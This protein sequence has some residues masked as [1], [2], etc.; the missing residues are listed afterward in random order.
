MK[1]IHKKIVAFS[2]CGVMLTSVAMPQ[3]KQIIKVVG[4]G[5]AVKQF[6]KDINRAINKLANRSD[7]AERMTKVVPILTV[8]IGK[9]NAIGA[10]QVTGP[11][12]LVDTVEA[13]AAP[14]TELFGKEIRIRAMIPVSS[15]D[16]GKGI[17]AV[18]G[19]GVSGIVDLKL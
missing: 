17:K 6:N 16:L 9:S 10:A 3:I 12:K 7:T 4:V 13:V 18:D 2:I 1:T 8:G 19:V 15:G 14:E 5:A 11:K